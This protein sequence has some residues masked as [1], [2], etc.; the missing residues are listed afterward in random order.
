MVARARR[1]RE[2]DR[3]HAAYQNTWGGLHLPPAPMYDG[4]PH[5]FQPDSPESDS[6]GWWFEAGPQRTAV[7]F[8]FM[9]GPSGEFGIQAEGARWAALHSTIE[10]WVEALALADHASVCAR[11]ITRL[12]GDEVD[13]VDLDDYESVLEVMGLAD[14]WW[15]GPDSLVALYTGEAKGLDFPGARVAVI[16][17]GLDEWGSTAT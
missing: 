16:Y 15:R 11:R 12:M 6:A 5:Y 10:G 7:P 3:P 9:I 8:T 13:G 2:R 4:G 17:S 1:S 14:T